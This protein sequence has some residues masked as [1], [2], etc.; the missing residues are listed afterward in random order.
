MYENYF[1]E[2]NNQSDYLKNFYFLKITDLYQMN[3][4]RLII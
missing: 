2:F 3:L 1:G 4:I